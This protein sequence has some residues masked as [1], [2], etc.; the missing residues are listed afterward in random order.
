M[1]DILVTRLSSNAAWNFPPRNGGIDFVTDP[2]SAH[3]SDAPIV[4]LVREIIQNSLDA[5]HTGYVDPVVVEFKEENVSRTLI[6]GE[7]LERHIAACF[8]RSASEGRPGAMATY[9]R[10]LDI[11]RQRTIRCLKAQDMGTIGLDDA[12]W[13]ALVVQEGAVSKTGGAPGGNYG[14]G[15]NAALN[16]S[17]LQTVF[18]STRY[19]AGR[20][21][22]VEKMQGKATLMG[23]AA[24]DN[25]SEQ[26][27]HIGF[28]AGP[29]GSPFMGR[30]IPSFFR[31]DETGTGVFIMGFD[32]RTANWV[33]DMTC[34]VIENFFHAVSDKQLVVRITADKTGHT[35]EIN[36]ETIDSLFDSQAARGSSA[37][38]YYRA[39]RDIESERTSRLTPL[40]SLLVHVVFGEGAPRRTALVNRNGM[41]IADS[42]D[43]RINP[44]SPRARGIWPDFAAVVIPETE[45]GDL[46]LRS[47][48]NPSHDSLST[49]QLPTEAERKDADNLFKRARSEIA[50]IIEDLAELEAYVDESNIDELT[51]VLPDMGMGT[52]QTLMATELIPR[53]QGE[54]E[55]W[56]DV[57]VNDDEIDENTSDRPSRNTGEEGEDSDSDNGD[58]SGDSDS[59]DQDPSER[60]GS[61]GSHP[62]RRLRLRN[63]RVIPVSATEAVIAFD[64]SEE[65]GDLIRLSLSPVGV[66]RDARMTDRLR[67]ID[68]Q[69]L[70]GIEGQVGI[71]DSQITLTPARNGR[72]S[73]KVTVDAD[74]QQTALRVM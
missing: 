42:K 5:K 70:R 45:R 10:A 36:H 7:S 19:I 18:Y 64:T 8:D 27:Q 46:W 43:L 65:G 29:D 53:S 26:L 25:P 35:V 51:G 33:E 73:V 61:N 12:R 21:G 17:D 1:G 16:V 74:I 58:H 57:D 66:D 20:R 60:G 72:M 24:P 63:V 40:G 52:D 71:D 68:A 38:H 49:E 22:R 2:S 67:V 6:G 31:L 55:A 14:I 69:A 41:L 48:E 11:S 4:K 30:N 34:A 54:S 50:G 37:V 3:F 47:M 32:P 59:D 13:N 28:F 62:A 44:L 39:V 15:K 9:K 56:L 23:H